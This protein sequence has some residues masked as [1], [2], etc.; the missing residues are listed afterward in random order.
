MEKLFSVILL[1]DHNDVKITSNLVLE[2]DL[3]V[4]KIILNN[5]INF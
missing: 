2:Q 5:V 4:I 1:T 3:G